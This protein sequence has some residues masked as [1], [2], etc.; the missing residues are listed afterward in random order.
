[1]SSDA[2]TKGRRGRKQDDTLEYSRS[3]EVQRAFRARRAAHLTNLEA[4]VAFLEREN[5]ELRRRSGLPEDGP[6][7]TGKEPEMIVV[8]GPPGTGKDKGKTKA[9]GGGGAGNGKGNGRS[10]SPVDGD[11]T[12]R[13]DG[14]GWDTAPEAV[15]AA[16]VLLASASGMGSYPLPQPTDQRW[17]QGQAVA[18]QH[19]QHHQQQQYMPHPPPHQQH[20]SPSTP[21]SMPFDVV[22][23]PTGPNGL[24]RH[25]SD[26]SSHSPQTGSSGFPSSSP[27]LPPASDV[28]ASYAPHPVPVPAHAPYGGP[29]Y[30]A[31]AFPPHLVPAAMQSPTTQSYGYYYHIQHHPQQQQ[32]QHPAFSTPTAFPPMPAP[33]PC[34]I[35]PIPPTPTHAQLPVPPSSNL[36]APTIP[37]PAPASVSNPSTGP[38]PL[39]P[40]VPPPSSE[41]P[42]FPTPEEQLF[43]LQH[44]CGISTPQLDLPSTEVQSEP[45]VKRD[46][47]PS[48]YQAFCVGLMKGAKGIGALEGKKRKRESIEA[49]DEEEGAPS[50]RSARGACCGGGS[51][52]DEEA[53]LAA[54]AALA[55]VK[56]SEDAKGAESEEECCGGLIDCS[57]PAFDPTPSGLPTSA[58]PAFPVPVDETNKTKSL[59]ATTIYLPRPANPSSCYSSDPT[60]S[61]TSEPPIMDAYIRVSQAYALLAAFMSSLLPSSSSPPTTTTTTTSSS[62]P[63]ARLTPAQ[64]AEMLH[65]DYE[66]PSST[67]TS[68]RRSGPGE[69]PNLV[70]VPPRDRA[71]GKEKGELYVLELAVERVKTRLERQETMMVT[72]RGGGDRGE[73]EEEEGA[74]AGAGGVDQ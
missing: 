35:S 37:A 55:T 27:H 48:S 61:A 42:A 45:G 18:K 16:E 50:K 53:A 3:R 54:A 2:P 33:R 11:G 40:L 46:K 56:Q 36:R 1:M 58:L 9:K 71:S 59:P 10:E 23:A 7:L 47:Q 15:G 6:P 20:L 44:F 8:E 21:S 30:V 43:F 60:S 73:K 26:Y 63:A 49:A 64:I 19:P 51:K 66:H 13:Q 41:G 31:Y 32:Q 12:E 69:P 14:G 67:S 39:P 25:P 4:R 52:E 22:P 57:G 38:A 70:I 68:P 29:P 34:A 74:G 5:K 65:D 24:H 17:Q 62:A 28:G 72:G